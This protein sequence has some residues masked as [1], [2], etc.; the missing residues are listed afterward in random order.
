MY[1]KRL[2]AIIATAELGSFSKAAKELDYT[3]PALV[4]QVNSFEQ[5]TGVIVFDRSNK[6]ITLT[7]AGRMLVDDARDIVERSKRAIQR[8]LQN[9]SQDK[10]VVRVGISLYQSGQPILS[11]IQKMY[12]HGIDL[13]ISFVPVA[14]TRES[15]RYTI[16]NLG[17][18]VDVL[19]STRLTPADEAKSNM[20]VLGNPFL[21]LGVALGDELAGRETVD[22]VELANRR[23]LVPE[24]GNV[25]TDS[26]RDEIAEKAPGVEFVE[27]PYYTME[28]FD[29][30]AMGEEVLLTKDIWRGIHPLIATVNVRWG[31]TIPYCLYY[32]KD[33]NP[34]VSKFVKAAVDLASS[35]DS[36]SYDM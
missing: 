20:A 14:D 21:C 13:R 10:D 17:E 31:H 25:Y 23:V 29:R 15:Y 30:C 7:S 28:V 26:A 12:K 9:Q 24:R 18:E 3:T 11:I 22:I 35:E 36:S 6:G 32:A 2:D 4:K 33:P 34:A 27:F 8:A 1:D 16:E 19:A 5:Q